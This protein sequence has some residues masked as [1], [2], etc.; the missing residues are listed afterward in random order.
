MQF[1][2]FLRRGTTVGT[3]IISALTLVFVVTGSSDAAQRRVMFEEFTSTTCP[4]CA[5]LAPILEQVFP[6]VSDICTES[7]YHM[8]WPGAGS[9]PWNADNREDN[10][11]S[12]INGGRRSYYA[13]N[14]VP[15]MI[16]DGQTYGGNYS[17]AA[18]TNAIRAR[19]N[20]PSPATMAVG[21][22][23]VDGRLSV[24][25]TV[26]AESAINT[27]LYI[28]L[29][30][31]QWHYAAEVDRN[32]D[33][34][35]HPMVKMIPDWRGTAVRLAAG[36]S[37]TFEFE[38]SMEGLGWHELAVDNLE[39]IAFLQ[40]AN[41]TVLQSGKM[42]VRPP[43]PSISTVEWSVS[44]Q[45]DGDGD[46]RAEPG[47]TVYMLFTLENSPDYSAAEMV[48]IDVT[49]TDP[50]IQLVNDF[51]EINGMES[52][53]VA[54]N[55]D[56]PISFS[57]P[58]GFVA[59]P[60]T[61]TVVTTAQPGDVRTESEI[62]FMIDWP[63]FLLID[64][65]NNGNATNAMYNLF[66][67]NSLPWADRWDRT[68]SGYVD[69]DQI[70]NYP[71]IIWH[72]FN[73]Q[74]PIDDFE[75]DILTYY[76]QHGGK[77]VISGSYIPQILSNSALMTEYLGVTLDN[78]NVPSSLFINGVANDP[79]FGGARIFPRGGNGAGTPALVSSFTVAEGARAVLTF[80]DGTGGSAGVAGVAHETEVYSTLVLGI[81]I[82]SIGGAAATEA[83]AAFM[84]RVWA[85]AQADMN[86]VG[87]GPVVT[88]I[89][90]ALNTAYPNPFNPSTV[91]SFSLPT[92]EAATLS[93]YDLS[94]RNVATLFDGVMAAGEHSVSFD[95]TA[96]GLGAGIYYAR[97]ETAGNVQSTQLLYLK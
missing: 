66:G 16:I 90:F 63:S 48:R 6:Q 70:L 8:N 59:H 79:Q 81:P 55:L 10:G 93:V 83:R 36:E 4:P 91:L 24:R 44:D 18:I 76:L 71:V 3:I 69:Q 12:G 64:A 85:W 2:N 1:V 65:S 34:H 97:L 92:S 51:F 23:I 68:E 52:G 53:A 75:A 38:Q 73:N 94:G 43:F 39:V 27:V 17:A 62:T 61:F 32:W 88:P 45:I 25:V 84:N 13:V 42:G 67:A 35:F 77:L 72:A 9:D 89:R 58:E 54:D 46:G 28:N 57:V 60:V 87:E 47:E 21:G 41:H 22:E 11:G 5:Q 50:D 82:E 56:N 30:E 96:H 20:T 33:E 74:T 78:P 14:G 29:N 26:T 37:E 15:T 19:L 40:D 7:V 80:D 31:E 95:A 86:A 49:T